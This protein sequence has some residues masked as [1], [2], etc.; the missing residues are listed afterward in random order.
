MSRHST[1]TVLY[2]LLIL[3]MFW[4]HSVSIIR[5]S[6]KLTAYATSGTDVTS[7][8]Y[9]LINWSMMHGIL[10]IKLHFHFLSLPFTEAERSPH[11]L[12]FEHNNH[13]LQIKKYNVY[14]NKQY[15]W[16]VETTKISVC[17]YHGK[18]VLENEFQKAINYDPT[19]KLPTNLSTNQ[20][21]YL[22]TYPPT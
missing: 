1:V 16:L 3:Y 13:T 4:T 18:I 2:F 10:N 8:G 21:T 5:R 22:L 17:Y 9:F 14:V 15:A 20:P 6:I 19:Y 11:R 7:V 12:T